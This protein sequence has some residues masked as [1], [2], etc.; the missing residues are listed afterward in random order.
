MKNERKRE[1]EREGMEG[2]REEKREGD[3]PEE[4]GHEG[5]KSQAPHHHKVARPP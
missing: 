1:R 4:R 2:K 5:E 3:V